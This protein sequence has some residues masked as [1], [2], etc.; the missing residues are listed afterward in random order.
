MNK[1]SLGA[2]GK[3]LI[4][5]IGVSIG[6]LLIM[7]APTA[8][9]LGQSDQL[10]QITFDR[11]INLL[12]PTTAQLSWQVAAMQYDLISNSPEQ[13]SDGEHILGSRAPTPNQHPDIHLAGAEIFAFQKQGNQVI[14]ER[15]IANSGNTACFR[16]K[17]IGKV[18]I[19]ESIVTAYMARPNQR[20]LEPMQFDLSDFWAIAKSDSVY[21]QGSVKRCQQI[22]Q[23]LTN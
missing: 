1:N 22:F 20:G 10:A 9:K 13:L 2:P 6:H 21:A 5:V 17:I 15:F 18:I 23:Q 16:G 12:R 8:A 11:A 4:G 19:A 3:V 7:I 14:G